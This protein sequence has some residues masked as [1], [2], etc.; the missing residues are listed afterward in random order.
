MIAFYFEYLLHEVHPQ[1]ARSVCLIP[2]A[3]A[4]LLRNL[5][6]RAARTRQAAAPPPPP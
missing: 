2:G 5:G 3:M 1:L 4:F 6:A